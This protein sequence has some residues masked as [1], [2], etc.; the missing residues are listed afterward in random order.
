M[1]AHVQVIKA[2]NRV[3]LSRLANADWSVT[4]TVIVI[5]QSDRASYSGMLLGCIANTNTKDETEI[6][7]TDLTE[8]AGIGD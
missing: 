8:W 2:F 1:H 3:S 4:A 7:W 5:D 6:S